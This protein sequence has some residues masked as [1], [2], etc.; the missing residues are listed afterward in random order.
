MADAALVTAVVRDGP[1]AKAG[2]RIHDF[3]LEIDGRSVTGLSGD[4]LVGR[5]RGR[6]GAQVGIKVKRQDDVMELSVR[7]GAVTVK[8]VVSDAFVD[9]GWRLAY[10]KIESFLR[11]DAEM[12]RAMDYQLAIAQDALVCSL[13]RPR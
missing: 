4:A 10:L 5:L 11:P 1:A 3:I 8:N 2:L 6:Q 12:S 9:R 7:L 13:T